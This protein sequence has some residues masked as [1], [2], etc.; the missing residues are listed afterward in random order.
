VLCQGPNP[1][2]G[3]ISAPVPTSPQIPRVKWPGRGVD[4][5]PHLAPRLKKELYVEFIVAVGIESMSKQSN[6]YT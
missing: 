4:Y 5:S 2:M 3:E 1:G 6:Q